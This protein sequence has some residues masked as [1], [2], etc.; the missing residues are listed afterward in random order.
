MI[1]KLLPTFLSVVTIL[2]LWQLVAVLVGY[3][4]IFPPLNQLFVDSFQLLLKSDFYTSLGATV[5]RGMIGFVLSFL[6]ALFAGGIAAHSR[7]W[8][9]FFNPIVVIIRSVPVISVVLVALLWFSPPQLPVFIALLTMFPVL[10]QSVLSGFE[11]VD[12][13]L[14][15]M[16]TVFGNSKWKTFLKIYLPSAKMLIISGVSTATGFGWRAIIIGEVLAQPIHGIGSGMKMAQVYLNVSELFAWTLVA[17]FISY[18]F[19]LMIHSL[20]K[21]RFSSFFTKSEAHLFNVDK[22]VSIKKITVSNLF[23]SFGNTAIFENMNF[24][25]SSEKIFLLKAPSGRGKT[26]YLRL[27]SGI[28]KP[29]SGKIASE[30]CMSVAYSF[31]DSRLCSWLTVNENIKFAVPIRSKFDEVP[32]GFINEIIT[33]LELTDEINK[34]PHQLSGGQQQR[35]ALARALAATPD[36]LLLDEPLNGLDNQLKLKIMKFIDEYILKNK[37]LVI[38][39]THEDIQLPNADVEEVRL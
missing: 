28:V 30:N 20:A 25:F 15:E 35:V 29:D 6:L 36:L 23:K 33:E 8:K 22:N 10:Y 39:A 1:K 13:K 7:F 31:Q 21:V 34:Y 9:Q 19:D 26:T 3:P 2:I 17:V 38:W 14:V 18:L 32:D 37:P 5:L 12:P 4:A 11:H 24:Q 16:S 27:L